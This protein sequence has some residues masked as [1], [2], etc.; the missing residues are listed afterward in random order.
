MGERSERHS[1]LWARWGGM[2]LKRRHV[3]MV[4]WHGVKSVTRAHTL[5][6]V[7]A[8]ADSVYLGAFCELERATFCTRIAVGVDVVDTRPSSRV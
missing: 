4:G 8:L 6:T 2:G 1:G 3:G 5:G 7:I